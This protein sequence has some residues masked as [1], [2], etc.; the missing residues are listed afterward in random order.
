[1]HKSLNIKTRFNN[2]AEALYYQAQQQ[3]QR[4][5]TYVDALG[6]KTIQS[7]AELLRGAQVILQ[8]LSAHNIKQDEVIILQIVQPRL[9]LS[10]FWACIL[11]GIIPVI[12][13]TPDEYDIIDG[14]TQKIYDILMFLKNPKIICSQEIAIKILAIRVIMYHFSG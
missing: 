11:G 10:T 7:Y 6:N 1:M 4:G 2:L 5:I 14:V 12:I 9:L 13:A 3:I 8:Q